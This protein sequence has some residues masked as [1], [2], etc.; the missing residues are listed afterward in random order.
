LAVGSSAVVLPVVLAFCS[1]SHSSQRPQ[2]GWLS[3]LSFSD[4]TVQVLGFVGVFGGIVACG[5]IT[6][7]P[8]LRRGVPWQQQIGCVLFLL[9]L[10]EAAFVILGVR[11]LLGRV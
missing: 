8:V 6:L 4:T 1:P 2:K 5:M 3:F 7:L 9:L 10:A 11:V